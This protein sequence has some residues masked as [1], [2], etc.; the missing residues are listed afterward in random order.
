MRRSPRHR[1]AGAV[2]ATLATLAAGCGSD[3]GELGRSGE[4]RVV[5]TTG[6]TTTGVVDVSGTELTAGLVPFT[7]CDDLLR[8]LQAEA[9]ERVG[10]YGLGGGLLH[11]ATDEHGAHLHVGKTAEV[12]G[13]LDRHLAFIAGQHVGATAQAQQVDRVQPPGDVVVID[14]FTF[15]CKVEAVVV[16]GPQAD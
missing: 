10:P 9:V 11:D 14:D 13:F 4:P 1:L 6:P 5:S 2:L 16:L 3:T 15:V 7:A 8:H 12:P